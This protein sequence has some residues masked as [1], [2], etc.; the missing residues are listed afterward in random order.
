M[1]WDDSTRQP[2]FS[3]STSTCQLAESAQ[4]STRLSTRLRVRVPC[5]C[6]SP[7]FSKFISPLFF[8]YNFL[9]APLYCANPVPPLPGSFA[10]KKRIPTKRQAPTNYPPQAPPWRLS[11]WSAAVLSLPLSLSQ[12]QPFSLC[13]SH[14]DPFHIWHHLQ[15][16]LS[17][18]QAGLPWQP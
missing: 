7:R 6:S 13:C 2:A 1:T 12:P 3:A 14:S 10:R 11:R 8:W 4:F 16:A 18:H 5:Q 9:P 17:S 15:P